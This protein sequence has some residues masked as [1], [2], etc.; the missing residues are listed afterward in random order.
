MTLSTCVLFAFQ[1]KLISFTLRHLQQSTRPTKTKDK[2]EAASGSSKKR[3]KSVAFTNDT[4]TEDGNSAQALFQD[5]AAQNQADQDTG[6]TPSEVAQFSEPSSTQTTHDPEGISLPQRPAKKEKKQKKPKSTPAKTSEQDTPTEKKTKVRH[7]KTS[8]R[9]TPEY[10]NYLQQFHTDRPSWKFNK[11][12][13]ND[14]LKNVWNIYRITPENDE[15]LVEYI[16]GLQGANAQQRLRTQ[17]QETLDGLKKELSSA[18]ADEAQDLDM[19]TAADRQQAY[20]RVV[21]KELARQL[22]GGKVDP[23]DEKDSRETQRQRQAQD[24]RAEKV[25]GIN[26]AAALGLPK[27]SITNGNATQP[28]ARPETARM[29]KRKRDRGRVVESDSSSSSDSSS[30]SS[31]ESS[32]ASDSDPG[33]DGSGSDTDSDSGGDKPAP[34]KPKKNSRTNGTISISSSSSSSSSSSDDSDA[35]SEDSDD[36]SSGSGGSSG[37]SGSIGSSSDDDDNDDDSTNASKKKAPKPKKENVPFDKDFLDQ[38]FP[39][40]KF[41]FQKK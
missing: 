18:L 34:K 9:P 7:S 5:W 3:R 37:S 21:Q 13:Q 16:S 38:V 8:D 27:E 15:A 12:K 35:D 29:L 4:K 11:S 2:S 14:L 22:E 6:F 30:D 31:S 10:I 20:E 33:S 40:K 41:A 17:A 19:S 32:S 36:A 1:A 23:K 24:D 26:I 28:P 25:L 39:K